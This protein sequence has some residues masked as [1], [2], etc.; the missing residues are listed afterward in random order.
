[1]NRNEY[2]NYIERK[3]SE[4]AWRIN[5]NS[6]QNLLHLHIHSENFYSHF[7]NI[8][9]GWDLG[10]T[11]AI[12]QN[13]EAVDLACDTH[14]IV[15][16]VSSTN[17]KQKIESALG[18]DLIKSYKEYT[19][20]FVSISNPAD[21]LR[22]LTFKNPHGIT[23]NPAADIIDNNSILSQLISLKTDDIKK[24]YEF[25][26]LEL[27]TEVDIIRRE[28]NLASII[29]IL[30]K[31][32]LDTPEQPSIRNSF[33]IDEKIDYN[34]L[35]GSRE[36]IE[37]YSVNQPKLDEKYQEF[38]KQAS[39]KSLSVLRTVRGIYQRESSRSSNPDVIFEHVIDRVKLLV[40]DSS[41]YV[42]IPVKEL[43]LCVKVI[44]VDAFMRCKIFKEIPKSNVTA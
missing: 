4:L 37:D 44:V 43:D 28:S 33:D 11:N 13:V 24:I 5:A 15:V 10:N 35:S 26:K 20:K 7:L 38:D 23:F 30:S 22:V 41:N 40:L 19:F 29:N 42:E 9:F 12:Q 18:K 39:N 25:I 1:M 2:Y 8:L 3:L 14:E 36:L 34:T 21:N 27:G 16:Q 31:E 17:T 6:K 32:N